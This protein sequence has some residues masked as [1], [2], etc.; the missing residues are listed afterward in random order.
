MNVI[1]QISVINFNIQLSAFKFNA[2]LL[3]DNSNTIKSPIKICDA[4]VPLMTEY[5]LKRITATMNISSKSRK[6]T[7]RNP[8][9]TIS[10]NQLPFQI[11]KNHF[12]LSCV[13]DIMCADNI[14]AIHYCDSLGN[15]SCS[16]P[17]AYF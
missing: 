13:F 17:F 8:I 5:N 12:H 6:E 14:R 9:L 15:D 4:I 2:W 10:N 1:I 7:L 16:I 11:L 3:N